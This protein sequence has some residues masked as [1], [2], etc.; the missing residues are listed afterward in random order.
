MQKLKSSD[1]RKFASVWDAIADTP[2][3]AARMRARS[4]LIMSLT[5]V[6]RERGMSQGDAADQFGVTQP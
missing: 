5:E 4:D 6:I 3:L 1:R 2:Q